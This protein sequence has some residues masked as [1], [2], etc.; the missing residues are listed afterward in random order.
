MLI[1][2]VSRLDQSKHD[3][4]NQFILGGTMKLRILLAPLSLLASLFVTPAN[5]MELPGQWNLLSD[6]GPSTW[7]MDGRKF[8]SYS[9]AFWAAGYSA[10]AALVSRAENPGPIPACDYS[11]SNRRWINA[12]AQIRNEISVGSRVLVKN[13]STALSPWSSS[14][15]LLY[16]AYPGNFN[17]NTRDAYGAQF[18][19]NIF[20]PLEVFPQP[21]VTEWT[22]L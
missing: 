4:L 7:T 11:S 9:S 1:E 16:V 6:Y 14:S 22:I 21:W 13:C 18:W 15:Q 5:A 10:S 20:L 2:S 12:R 3:R 17:W 19:H 8:R